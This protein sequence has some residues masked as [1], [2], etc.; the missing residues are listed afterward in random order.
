[1]SRS[2]AVLLL[3]LLLALGSGP[4]CRSFQ[5]NL[6][7]REVAQAPPKPEQPDPAELARRV[8][9]EHDRR[10]GLVEALKVTDLKI[11]VDTFTDQ[12]GRSRSMFVGGTAEGVLV[13]ERPR[14]LRILLKKPLGMSVADIGSND[15]EFWFAN[16]LAHEM[17][18]GSYAQ[19]EGMADPFLAS[20]RPGWIFE[21]LGLEPIAAD[22]SI[23]RGESDALLTIVEDRTLPNGVKMVKESILSVPEQRVVE[24]RLYSEG[25]KELVAQA[26][27]D[28]LVSLPIGPSD[29]VNPPE[30]I[31]IPRF[32]QLTIPE[33]A[34]LRMT[35]VGIEPN[36]SDDF[37]T[38]TS[39]EMPPKE[40]YQVVDLFD[41]ASRAG[42]ML[43]DG[44]PT[45][46]TPTPPPIPPPSTSIADAPGALVLPRSDREVARVE[47][48]SG[49][50]RRP[51]PTD[52]RSDPV[53]LDLPSASPVPGVSTRRETW[54]TIEGNRFRRGV[55]RRE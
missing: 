54:D 53:A 44:S 39:F 52:V 17:I 37:A 27:V 13:M 21:V 8:A 23:E 30:T 6:L 42:P 50:A 1:M 18:V 33:V 55:L 9:Q 2:T 11:Q 12:N 34:E 20:V 16:D 32:V 40:G 10:A 35:L 49:A 48:V 51:D 24:H 15:R 28:R 36:P 26:R 22:A 7:R 46:T 4:G 47:D 45:A 5:G 19:A 3:V 29:G 25:R 43:A 31:Q 14:N 38:M 41:L